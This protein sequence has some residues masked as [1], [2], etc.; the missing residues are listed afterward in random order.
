MGKQQWREGTAGFVTVSFAAVY[1]IKPTL[2]T[3]QSYIHYLEIWK[4]WRPSDDRYRD[5]H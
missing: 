4:R 2:E 3:V 5:G 1:E